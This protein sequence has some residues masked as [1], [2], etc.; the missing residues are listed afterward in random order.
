[1]IEAI[2]LFILSL[3]VVILVHEF[4]HFI[5]SKRIGV[6]VEEFGIG[7]PPRLFG[8]VWKGT[9]YSLN[10]IPIGAFVRSRGENDPSVEG[11]LAGQG[12]WHRLLVY[13]AG[14]GANILLAF[15]LLTTFFA[16]PRP[17]VLS[18]GLL[19]YQVQESAPAQQ[20][21]MEAGDIILTANDESLH[22][23]NDLQMVLARSAAQES[24]Q[25]EILR[26]GTHFTVNVVP[27]HSETL[28]RNVIGITLGHNIVTAVLPGSP[29]D[30][31]QITKGDSVLGVGGIRV[32]NEASFA[33]RL[34][35]AADDATTIEL[36]LL[37]NAET[38]TVEFANS[39]LDSDNLGLELQWAPGT[40]I[41]R[42][43]TPLGT[44]A[45]SSGIFIISM[46]ALIVESIPLM[47][48]DPSLAF[49]GPIGAGQLTVEAVQ[50]F[51]LSNLIFIAGL[52]SIGIALFNLIPIP[53]LDG[54]GILVSLIEAARRGRRLSERSLRWAYAAGT[55]LLITLV[56]LITM[57]DVFR[58]IEGRGFGL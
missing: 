57:S 36:T 21:G 13:V 9:L 51:G 35:A 58:L 38:Y 27:E 31:S 1:M 22:T 14:P 41:E 32:I 42:H 43:T 18:D 25:L 39:D 52:I 10:A 34:S 15:L 6:A 17:V 24:V 47:Q 26:N 55:A 20:A 8:R 16:M 23:W 48:E 3:F 2:L 37:S 50:T 44:A 29:A 28:G 56:I 54:G 46:P 5:A 7:F 49:V 12:P 45:L 30:Q 11:S 19:V 4:G 40:R 53:P 33:E